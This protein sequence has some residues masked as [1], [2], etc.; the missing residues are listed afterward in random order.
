MMRRCLRCQTR[1]TKR[2][3]FMRYICE[4]CVTAMMA[5]ATEQ[6]I[7]QLVTIPDQ[8]LQITP[9]HEVVIQTRIIPEDL[10][11]DQIIRLAHGLAVEYPARVSGHD[12]SAMS[13]A[14]VEALLDRA[15]PLE[16]P[17]A[18]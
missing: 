6:V 15:L 7:A 10:T 5:E 18:C 4:P 1:L 13:L 11:S 17:E 2:R 12:L 14:D 3:S 8:R 16:D 9:T